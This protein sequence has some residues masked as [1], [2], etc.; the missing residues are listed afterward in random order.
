M[1]EIWLVM[2]AVFG[3]LASSFFSG[4]EMGVYSVNNV[5]L[6]V[7]AGHGSRAARRLLGLVRHYESLVITTLVGTN[8]ADYVVTACITAL[9][10]RAAGVAGAELYATLI[11]TPAVLVFGNIIPKERFRRDNYALMTRFATPLSVFVWI[12]RLTG[13]EW[14]LTQLSRALVRWVDPSQLV[15]DRDLLPRARALKLLREGAERGGL[16]AFQRDAFDRIM[17]LSRTR[18]ARVMVHRSRAA[19]APENI[20]RDDFLRIA[21][22]AHFAR[23]PVYRGDPR[24]VVG[25]VSVFDVLMDEQERPVADFVRPVL[26][27]RL[28]EPA[29]R[30]LRRMQAEHQVMAVVVDSRGRCVGLLTIKDLLEEIIGAVEA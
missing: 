2:G 12:V 29:T 24:N 30:A 9:A 5:K 23:L 16:T 22:M 26:T 1:T 17:Q 28:S 7:E 13:L 10:L 25:V 18:V 15:N 8:I 21:R 14:L 4:A 19:S 27:L 6:R 11:V 20:S 3:L